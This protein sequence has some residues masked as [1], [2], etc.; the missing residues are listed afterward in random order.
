MIWRRARLFLTAVLALLVIVAPAGAEEPRSFVWR[1]LEYG[2]AALQKLDVYAP[3]GVKNAPIIFMVHGGSWKYGDKGLG[4]TLDN[5]SRHYLG[6]NYIFVSINYRMLPEADPVEQA[7]DVATAIAYVQKKAKKWGGDRKRMVLIG[8]SAGAHLLSLVNA[9]PAFAQEAGA[10]TWLG[11]VALDSGAYDVERLMTR[12]HGALYDTAFGADKDYW[13]KASPAAQV[14]GHPAP[15]LL[16]CSTKWGEPCLQS[17][18][19]KTALAASGG[20]AQVLPV[21]LSH[22]EVNDNLGLPTDYTRGVDVFLTGLGLPDRH[23]NQK[24]Q[25]KQ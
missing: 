16:V 22:K 17:D 10:D 21:D 9:N 15:M 2:D 12:K 14:S 7:R 1:D 24:T 4:N 5:K 3:H 20:A 13:R 19:F 18:A 8:H 25:E 23:E 6:K 11:V